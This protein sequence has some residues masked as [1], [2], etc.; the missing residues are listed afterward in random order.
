MKTPEKPL[1]DSRSRDCETARGWGALSGLSL[2][3]WCLK[4]LTQPCSSWD[5]LSLCPSFH[6]RGLPCLCSSPSKSH[7]QPGLRIFILNFFSFNPWIKGLI[8]LRRF[9]K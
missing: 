4:T 3:S 7:L 6:R 9:K 2:H 1:D 5:T 8:P